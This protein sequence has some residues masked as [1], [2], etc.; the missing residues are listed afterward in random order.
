M[1]KEET[2]FFERIKKTKN[3]AR[4]VAAVLVLLVSAVTV[5]AIYFE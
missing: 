4:F 3:V 2:I 1:K 5:S